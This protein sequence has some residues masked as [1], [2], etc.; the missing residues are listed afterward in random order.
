MKRK[1]VNRKFPGSSDSKYDRAFSI[2]LLSHRK[3]KYW[4]SAYYIL[5]LIVFLLLTKYTSWDVLKSFP[6]SPK[7]NEFIEFMQLN[8]D[9]PLDTEADNIIER[10]LKFDVPTHSWRNI[11]NDNDHCSFGF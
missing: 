10:Q 2:Y 11:R 8:S 3:Y 1:K 9:V 4:I 6:F 5:S 7:V